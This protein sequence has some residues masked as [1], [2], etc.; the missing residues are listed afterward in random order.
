[1]IDT[2]QKVYPIAL[3]CE[4]DASFS[5]RVLCLEKAWKISKIKSV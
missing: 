1:M 2:E 5:E 3:L 4:V